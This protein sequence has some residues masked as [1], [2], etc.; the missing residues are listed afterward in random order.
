MELI[1]LKK[2]ILDYISLNQGDYDLIESFF[3]FRTV[4][5]GTSIIEIGKYAHEVFFINSGYL[6][7]FKV[8]DSGEELIVHIYAPDNF[9]TSLNS[10]FLG[11]LSEEELQAIT[12]CDLVYITKTDLEKLY[13][14]NQKWQY[15]GRKLM[16]SFLVEKE[17]KIIDQLSLNGQ[18]KYLKLFETNP[19]IIQNVQVKYLASFLGIQ[20][21]SL[22]RI[23]KQIN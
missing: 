15:F 19:D 21:E 4:E 12:Q 20:P 6:K 16:E 10:F 17:Q 5:R 7:Y 1:K 9:A 2:R 22:S 23:K 13:S 3:N 11:K 18:Q 8:L 14:T